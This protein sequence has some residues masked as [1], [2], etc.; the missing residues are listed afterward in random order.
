M[1]DNLEVVGSVIA[2]D[3]SPSF[4]AFRFKANAF[5]Y[6]Y[7]GTLLGTT[8]NDR[9]SFLIGRV[10]KAIEINP[11][12]SAERSK[13]REAMEMLPDY[14]AE[15]FS[16]TIFRVYEVD[17]IEEAII[18]DDDTIVIEQ[19]SNMPK[20]GEEVFQL[21]DSIV[22]DALGFAT[23]HDLSLCL[24]TTQ[25][26][27]ATS[28]GQQATNNVMLKREAIQRHLF[29]G[30]TTGSGKSYSTGIILEEINRLGLPIVILDSQNEYAGLAK[31][32]GGNVLVPGKDYTVRLSSLT[33]T[34]VLDLVPTLRGTKGYDLLAFTFIRLK[35]EMLRRRK[36]SFN[37]DELLF[38]M[39]AD[40]PGLQVSPQSR[41]LGIRRTQSS[42][43]R[44]NFLGGKTN[45]KQLLSWR[46]NNKTP[47]LTIDCNGLDQTQ[48]QLIV[49][50][51]LR[52]LQTLRKDTQIPPY[53]VVLDE[54]HLLV[55]EGEGS[56]CKQVIRE[57][58]RLGRHF[59]ICMILITQSPVDIDKKTIRQCNTRLIFALE[60]DQLDAIRGV[61]ADA[62]DD[63]LN[64]LPK[65][66][67]GTCLLS[68][69]Y[70]TVKHAIPIRIRSDRETTPGGETP[71]IFAEVQSKW[72]K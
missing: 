28:D 9:K 58:V 39:E 34:E 1:L 61:R 12:E 48:L 26:S 36:D 7:P 5:Q 56:A 35:R 21:S 67:V 6:V 13:V 24:G 29:I 22:A 53:T 44:H 59:G 57:G 41:T 47:I 8:G 14:P 17:I 62:T 43:E 42:I 63:M 60:P 55:P 52:E 19:P 2:D 69:T 37:L 51:T 33:E 4:E 27:S 71:D 40:A 15:D 31:C 18:K 66:P 50:A 20:A 68:G 30:G 46:N 64:R 3:T 25:H 49:A 23:N 45:W 54:A 38:G 65:M 32:L 70:E 72:Q 10:S 11:H 16:T